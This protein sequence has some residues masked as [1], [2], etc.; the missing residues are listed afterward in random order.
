MIPNPPSF[1][2]VFFGLPT[3]SFC[4]YF[5]PKRKNINRELNNLLDQCKGK[6]EQNLIDTLALRS[7]SKAE[8]TTKNIGHYGLGFDY[9]THFTSPR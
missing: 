3:T 8:Y 7:M 2:D 5:N 1:V 6:K 9:Y 4:Y